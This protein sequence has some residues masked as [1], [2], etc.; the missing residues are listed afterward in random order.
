MISIYE[1]AHK[2]INNVHF[3]AWECHSDYL[4]VEYNEKYKTLRYK[5]TILLLNYKGVLYRNF[6][7]N[8]S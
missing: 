7:P 6:F 3:N 4:T 8:L 5:S 2:F 1:A